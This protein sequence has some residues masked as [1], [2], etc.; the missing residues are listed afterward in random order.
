M[1][2]PHDRFATDVVNEVRVEEDK[3]HREQLARHTTHLC[4]NNWR[5]VLWLTGA[6]GAGFALGKLGEQHLT[7]R[8]RATP[9]VIG[10]VLSIASRLTDPRRIRFTHKAALAVGG[11][12]LVT[13]TVHFTFQG[14]I[15]ADR[16]R[17]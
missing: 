14:R 13:S 3:K 4:V 8:W 7:G 1:A 2:T 16:T 6:L 11:L 10:L 12:A 17:L 15:D 9:L 5:D